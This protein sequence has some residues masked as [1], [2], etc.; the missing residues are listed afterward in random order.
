MTKDKAQLKQLLDQ[1]V[2]EYNR[3]AFID[4]DPVC[5]PHQ[6]SSRQDIEISAFWTAI[7]SWGIRKTI[8]AKARV[9]FALMDNAPYDFIVNHEEEDR[10]RLMS[11][12][13][14]TFQPTDTLYFV[15]FLQNYYRHHES[16]EDAFTGSM[17]DAHPRIEDALSGFHKLFFASEWAPQRTRK[18]ISTPA[19][20]A[21]CKRLNMFLR[22]M[23]RRDG[24]GVDF[25]LWRKIDPS[26]LI[27]PL[28][29]HV[30]R[31]ARRLGLL[32]RDK[33]DWKA[34]LE[35]TAELR[36]FDAAD[37]VKYDYALFGMGVL[38]RREEMKGR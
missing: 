15:D 12:K 11:F 21:G 8:I 35:L 34:A 37:P 23:V 18:H 25:G 17:D 33:T 22:W 13:H 30:H 26:I 19:K 1:R 24:N 38:E 2:A 27:I 28:D 32:S 14:R 3:P 29:V 9:L 20:N 16:L 6:F 7:L 36:T 4:D 31:V 5:V 10:R